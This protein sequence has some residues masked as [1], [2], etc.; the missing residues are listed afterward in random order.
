MA[1]NQAKPSGWPDDIVFHPV[2]YMRNK[3]IEPGLKNRLHKV[4]SKRHKRRRERGVRIK[5]IDKVN[6]PAYG[7]RGLFAARK[8]SPGEWVIDYA[9]ELIPDTQLNG[10]STDYCLKYVENH[11]IDAGKLGNESRFVNDFRGIATRPNVE[12]AYDQTSPPVVGFKALGKAIKKGEEIVATYGKRYW[13]GRGMDMCQDSSSRDCP[14]KHG[15]S[16]PEPTT[17]DAS[18]LCHLCIKEVHTFSNYHYCSMCNYGICSQCY[19]RC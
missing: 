10:R 3:G 4:I 14:G 12:F 16:L 2:V 8:F 1:A 17:S 7:Q 15:L 13:A 19:Q 11:S 9:G 6:H 5:V 18:F